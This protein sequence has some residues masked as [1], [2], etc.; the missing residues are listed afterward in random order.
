MIIDEV[1]S[2]ISERSQKTINDCYYEDRIIQITRK[3]PKFSK[4]IEKY[5]KEKEYTKYTNKLSL[6]S[7]YSSDN[8]Q[9]N[10]IRFKGQLDKYKSETFLNYL[11]NDYSN[12]FF[13]SGVKGCGKTTRLLYC[14]HK[15]HLDPLLKI[16]R[17]V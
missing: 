14:S 13:F 6:I 8:I 12:V 1:N 9:N 15:L 17:L 11:F 2:Q 7:Q 4:S 16:P 10:L 3:E 5:F